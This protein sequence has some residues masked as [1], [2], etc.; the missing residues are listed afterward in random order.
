MITRDGVNVTVEWN[1]EKAW[2][3]LQDVR[4]GAVYEGGGV[5][6]LLYLTS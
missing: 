5:L 3:I 4:P 6:L 1:A 2:E